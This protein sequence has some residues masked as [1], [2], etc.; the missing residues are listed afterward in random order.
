MSFWCTYLISVNLQQG[1]IIY[2]SDH[3]FRLFRRWNE[4]FSSCNLPLSTLRRA[5]HRYL[6]LSSSQIT[7]Q[8]TLE[9]GIQRRSYWRRR[10]PARFTMFER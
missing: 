1:T 8:C 4:R 5:E 7:T 10:I 2:T 9:I 6:D 3:T